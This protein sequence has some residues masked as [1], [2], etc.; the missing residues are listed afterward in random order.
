MWRLLDAAACGTLVLGLAVTGC[1]SSSSTPSSSTQSTPAASS[2]QTSTSAPTGQ[3]Q[4]PKVIRV[5]SPV[6]KGA[7]P[8]SARYTCD[9]ADTSPP[10]QWSGIPP[11]TA[12]LVLFIIN[13]NSLPGNGGP[14]IYW[15][16][17]DLNPA[18]QGIS[19]GSLPSGAVVGRNSLGQ[20]RYTICPTK[21]DGMQHYVVALFALKHALPTAAGFSAK[22]LYKAAE[23]ADKSKGL[24]L[25]SYQR[26]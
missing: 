26:R 15:A 14:L 13:I 19:A 21:S 3:E 20:S 2:P 18:L 22:A 7:T 24:T 1:G 12:E 23:T 6:F 10:V 9:G 25:F 16:V 8:I 4:A 11:G 17:A 5:S